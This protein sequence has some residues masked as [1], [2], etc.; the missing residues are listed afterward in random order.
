VARIDPHLFYEHTEVAVEFLTRA[1][2]FDEW[3]FATA[4][5]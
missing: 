2:G 4:A 5:E 3:S 1:Y